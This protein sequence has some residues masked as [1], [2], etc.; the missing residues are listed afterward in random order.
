MSLILVSLLYHR[1]HASEI[2]SAI[3][4]ELVTMVGLLFVDDTDLIAFGNDADTVPMELITS[5]QAAIHTWQAGLFTTGGA[6]KPEKCAWGILAYYFVAGQARMYNQ[7]RLPA[8]V[9]VRNPAGELVEIERKEPSEAITVVGVVQALN[10]DMK[11]QVE[12]LTHKADDWAEKVRNG[13][14]NRRIAWAGL[15]RM[16]WPSL[17]YPLRS[18][19]ISRP[20]GD[21][22]MRKLYRALLPELGLQRR[23]PLLWRHAPRR[24]QGLALPHPYI[25]QGIEQVKVLLESGR[26]QELQGSLLRITIEQGQLEVGTSRPLLSEKFET[27]GHLHTKRCW[28]RSLWEFLSASGISLSGAWMT[29]P[30]PQRQN[31]RYLMELFAEIGAYS[32]KDLQVLNRCRLYAQVMFLSDIVNGL[33]NTIRGEYLVLNSQTPLPVGSKWRWPKQQPTRTEWFQWKTALCTLS[34]PAGRLPDDL[35]LGH[36]VR[37]PHQLLPWR[38][39]DTTGSL[40]RQTGNYWY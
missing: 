10:G 2:R 12:A 33:G 4:N 37:S 26:S 20:Q 3:A 21:A 29:V 36:W 40:F 22:I 30:L 11:P 35:Q 27:W 16:I 39:D 32:D 8:S 1:G 38:Y 19:S 15:E 23:F 24:Y 17:A 6:L 31:D 5:L 13:W 25:A 18:C 14:L 7:A 28:I 34:S 9:Y